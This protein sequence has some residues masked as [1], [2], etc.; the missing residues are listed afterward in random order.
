MIHRL[1]SLDAFCDGC[2]RSFG[3][4]P[5][6]EGSEEEPI[7]QVGNE[8]TTSIREVRMLMKEHGWKHSDK[9]NLDLCPKCRTAR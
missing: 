6:V 9:P 3:Y 4:D 1:I 8:T 2:N 7:M 5:D